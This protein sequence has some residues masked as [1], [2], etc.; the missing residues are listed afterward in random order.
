VSARGGVGKQVN[1]SLVRQVVAHVHGVRSVFRRLACRVLDQHRSAKLYG[2]MVKD[3]EPRL[4]ERI[5]ELVRRLH[6]LEN[7]A[8]VRCSRPKA[9]A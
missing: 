2:R 7:V 8:R 9:G 5:H 3:D 6:V 1:P 4:V